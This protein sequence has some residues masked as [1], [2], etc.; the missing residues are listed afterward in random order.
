MSDGSITRPTLAAVAARA[1]VSASTAS[2]V[3]SGSGPVATATRERVLAA[4][5]ELDYAGPDPR[6][7][8]LRRGRSGIVGIV[9]EDALSDSLRDPMNLSLLDGIAAGLDDDGISLLLLAH[10]GDDASA[11]ASAPID[12]AVLLG[13]SASVDVPVAVLG[14]RGIPVV[15]V[16]T[17]PFERVLLVDVENR[18]G[19]RVA[20]EH[21]RRLGHERVAM[22]TMALDA[23]R[24]RGPLTPEREQ[25]ATG[26]TTIERIRGV[27][28]V[29]PD[30]TGE[31][32]FGSSADEGLAAARRLLDVPAAERPTA[33]IAQSDLLAV[34]VLRAAEELGLDVPGEVSVVGFDG[35]RLDGATRHELT[36]IVQDG[37]AKGA[38]VAGALRAA[39]AGEDFA[40]VVLPCALRVGTTTG[41]APA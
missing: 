28:E 18:A 34:G 25:A 4:A 40:P 38:A 41:P 21:L 32:A 19:S 24:T 7:R 20:A 22:V 8:S 10:A 36:T 2:L 14:R 17:A 31:S 26:R 12:A 15:G 27:R 29:F 9:M 1:G 5:S 11:V 13:C 39:F 23:A 35:I 16:E 6:A 37:V 33:I 30:A 3:F